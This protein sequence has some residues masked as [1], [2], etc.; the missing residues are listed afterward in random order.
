MD[1]FLYDRDL[2]HERVD[3]FHA[4]V[5]FYTPLETIRKLEVSDVFR[6]YRNRPMAWNGLKE[7]I[8]SGHLHVHS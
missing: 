7:P 8:P 5:S 4:M 2:R 3:Q 6:G 1:W